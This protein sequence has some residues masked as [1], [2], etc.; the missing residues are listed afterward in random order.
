MA[1]CKYLSGLLTALWLS[2][3]VDAA[4]QSKCTTETFRAIL[5][6]NSAASVNYVASV[7]QG[8]SFGD[9]ATN[10]AFP[11][12][13]TDLPALC[14]VSIN[15]VSSSTSSFNFGI[16]LPH[17]WNGRMLTTGNGGLGGGINYPDMGK[18]SHYGFATVS[19]DTGHIS[20]AVNGTWA[21]NQPEKIIDW[22]WR[23]M[24]GSVVT[25]KHIVN[26]FY[27]RSLSYSYYASCSTGEPRK[28]SSHT[29]RILDS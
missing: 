24:H 21:L 16:F 4:T 18:F 23:A 6:S 22:G 14:A 1:P 5:T 29:E 13:A 10:L 27:D 25:A 12:N 19:T 15:I 7:P 28:I 8:G 26:A 20:N 2:L 9:G 3:S 17:S 11:T